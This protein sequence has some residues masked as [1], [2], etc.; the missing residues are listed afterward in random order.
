MQVGFLE[1][2]GLTQSKNLWGEDA[3]PACPPQEKY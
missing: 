1:G 2:W 3:L